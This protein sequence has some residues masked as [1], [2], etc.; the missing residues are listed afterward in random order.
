MT[1]LA[2]TTGFDY[3]EYSYWEC[4]IAGTC[5]NTALIGKTMALNSTVFLDP[6]DATKKQEF[7]QIDKSGWKGRQSGGFFA[8]GPVVDTNGVTETVALGGKTINGVT[9][10][11]ATNFSWNSS[12]GG[13]GGGWGGWWG[14]G[15]KVANSLKSTWLASNVVDGFD[16]QSLVLTNPTT[17]TSSD[18][19]LLLDFQGL[20]GDLLDPFA[21]APSMG[22][23][24]VF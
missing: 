1:G 9:T 11:A 20:N 18:S 13:G 16:Y 17:G 19:Q 24:P 21:W 4:T 2:F 3:T 23:Q 8:S 22:T 14:G 7:R 10:G 15:S 5:N 6:F 12:S